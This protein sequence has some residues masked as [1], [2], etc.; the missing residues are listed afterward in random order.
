MIFTV[1]L[2]C[3][4]KRYETK[5]NEGK[6]LR[7]INNKITSLYRRPP[8]LEGGFQASPVKVSKIK[9]RTKKFKKKLK[10]SRSKLQVPLFYGD[11]IKQCNAFLKIPTDSLFLISKGISF[12]SLNTKYLICQIWFLCAK[13]RRGKLETGK[14]VFCKIGTL[15]TVV[16]CK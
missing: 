5:R 8:S 11:Y 14:S 16:S 10:I 15:L 4:A 3:F 7:V 1:G 12:H 6:N 2:L 9:K 13:T